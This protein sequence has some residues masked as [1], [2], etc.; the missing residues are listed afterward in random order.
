MHS[1]YEIGLQRLS[2]VY[3]GPKMLKTDCGGTARLALHIRI[4]QVILVTVVML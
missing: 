4:Q 1:C 2:E 3:N